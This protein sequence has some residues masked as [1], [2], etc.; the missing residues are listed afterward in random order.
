M[1]GQN[2]EVKSLIKK[3]EAGKKQLKI[4]FDKNIRAIDEA[5]K[6][7]S[8][9]KADPLKVIGS[10]VSYRK[11][12]RPKKGDVNVRAL[13]KKAKGKVGRGRPSG[14]KSG[15]AVNLTQ[16]LYEFVL[17]KNRFIHSREIVDN[18]MKKF[19]FEDRV[20][21]GKKISVLLA[22]LKKQKRLVTFKDGGYRKNMYW[23]APL[24]LTKEGRIS[25]GKEFKKG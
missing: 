22:S 3:L 10:A 13:V 8:V 12:G 23:G 14:S 4:E 24:W 25:K 19:P 2:T 15:V 20:D 18:V 5:I 21:F 1:S 17:S 9:A 11:P 16:M 6:T 7:L